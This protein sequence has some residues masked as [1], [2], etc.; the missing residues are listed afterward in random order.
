MAGAVGPFGKWALFFE[1]GSLVAT[2]PAPDD[3][4]AQGLPTGTYI[5]YH[6]APTEPG[7]PEGVS[8]IGNL[9][10]CADLS[11]GITSR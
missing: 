8:C 6:V 2:A 5:L 1:D 7:D 3:I 11:N 10:N 4:D 9:P